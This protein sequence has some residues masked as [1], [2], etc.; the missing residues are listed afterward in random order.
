MKMTLYKNSD[1]TETQRGG[2]YN[3]NIESSAIEYSCGR[4]MSSTWRLNNGEIEV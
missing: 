2:T 4:F 3:P 1:E